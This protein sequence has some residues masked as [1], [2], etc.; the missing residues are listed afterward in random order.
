MYLLARRIAQFLLH[1]REQAAALSNRL[2]DNRPV[3]RRVCDRTRTLVVN[4]V[5]DVFEGIAIVRPFAGNEREAESLVAE[6][7]LFVADKAPVWE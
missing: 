3:E 6:L 7:D 5:H 2:I 4:D 1:P